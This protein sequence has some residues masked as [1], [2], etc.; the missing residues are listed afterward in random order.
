VQSSPGAGLIW[1]LGFALLLWLVVPAGV[2]HVIAEGTS[3]IGRVDS[4]RAQFPQLVAYV[5]LFGMP[6]GIVLGIWCGLRVR[7]TTVNL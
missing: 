3:A 6:L 7:P 4:L 1:G 2:V 5:L